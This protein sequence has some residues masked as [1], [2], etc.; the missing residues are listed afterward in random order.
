MLPL[1]TPVKLSGG[2]V[3]WLLASFLQALKPLLEPEAFWFP[4]DKV[5]MWWWL[6]QWQGSEGIGRKWLL[7]GWLWL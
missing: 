5:G 7:D 2:D 3:G 4:N 1:A 6:D